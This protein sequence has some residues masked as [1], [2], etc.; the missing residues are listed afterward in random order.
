MNVKFLGTIREAKVFVPSGNGTGAISK[1]SVSTPVPEVYEVSL[2]F[3][4][5]ISEYGN[6]MLSTSFNSKLGPNSATVG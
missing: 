2:T 1:T 5:L 6:T 3:K 4:S